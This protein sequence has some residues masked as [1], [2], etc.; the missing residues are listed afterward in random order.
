QSFAQFGN[1]PAQAFFEGDKATRFFDSNGT[2]SWFVDAAAGTW[3]PDAHWGYP[4]GRDRGAVGFFSDSGRKFGVFQYQDLS[5]NSGILI[6]RFDGAIGK[7]VA[8]YTREKIAYPT[9]AAK[10]R[11]MWVVRH[12]TNRDG[13]IDQNDE[14]GTPVLDVAGKPIE[15]QMATR[16]FFALP[17]GSLVSETGSNNP[18][19][20]GF[21][22]KRKG[23]DRDGIPVYE[24]GPDSLIAVKKRI[25]PSAYDFDKTEDLAS[26][27]ES[28]I[29]SNGDYL[30][31]FQF[32][33]SPNGAG[34]S[35]SGGIDLARFNRAGDMR[36]LR[37]M[38]DF[39]PVQ[40]VKSIGNFT[41]SSWG[42]QAEWMGMND[43]GLSLGHLGYPATIGWTG[44][45]VDHPTQYK[46]FKGNDGRLQVLV[47]DYMQNAQH[48]LSL[49]NYDN[50]VQSA[51]DLK[52]TPERARELAFAPPVPYKL[53]AKPPQ[54]RIIVKKLSH[55]FPIDGKLAK[56]RG[57]TPQ[58]IITPVTGVGIDSPKDASAVIR[59]A[60]RDDDLYV[61]IIRFDDVPTFHQPYSKGHLQDTVEMSL[62]GFFD[63]FQFSISK[64]TDIGPGIVRRRF[65]FNKLED[66]TP[67]DHAPRVI[68]VLPNAKDVEE[69]KLIES[70]YG[71]DMSDCKVIVTEFKLPI[72]KITYRGAEDAIFPVKSGAGFWIG[73][74]IDDNDTPGA[75]IQKMLVWPATYGTFNVKETGAWAVFE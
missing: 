12:D 43:D 22:W 68:E 33:H 74:A 36:W 63:G 42:H 8:F 54:P 28:A 3:R 70:I 52:I 65:F 38:N 7:Q 24:F 66:L 64:F 2:V 18:P 4:P 71:Q 29:A 26:Q 55:P 30:A 5:K 75:D 58:I 49:E 40:G 35:N 44:Y 37:P 17:D 50:Y 46:L 16:F 13:V 56:W 11:D 61:Q 47:G 39:G 41:L 20:I 45:W 15:W 19:G 31:T 53:L 9:D 27:S 48:W 73:F 59:L 51:S 57:I 1:W 14:P 69:R 62:N 6:V 25:V 10:K 23:L 60:Y 21:I 67:A 34:L 72:D 32:G